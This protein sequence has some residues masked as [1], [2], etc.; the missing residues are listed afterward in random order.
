MESAY[1]CTGTTA[2]EFDLAVASLDPIRL[3]QGA[4]PWRRGR[5]T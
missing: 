4:L 5:G 3:P 1:R 2:L